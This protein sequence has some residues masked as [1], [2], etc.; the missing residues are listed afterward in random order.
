MR[1]FFKN[2]YDKVL[3]AL[4]LVLITALMVFYGWGARLLVTSFNKVSELR[5]DTGGGAHFEIDK[6]ARLNL[7]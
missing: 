5:P 6:A 3:L 1:N 2:H 7:E 4:A